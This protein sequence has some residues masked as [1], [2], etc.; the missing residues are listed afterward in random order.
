MKEE[1]RE[2]PEGAGARLSPL[3]AVVKLWKR[4]ECMVPVTLAC[5]LA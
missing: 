4:E 5:L 2:H 1:L 3:D